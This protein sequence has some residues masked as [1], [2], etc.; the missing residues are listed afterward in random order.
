MTSTIKRTLDTALPVGAQS[1][2]PSEYDSVLAALT[3]RDYTLT[4]QIVDVVHMEF[5]TDIDTVRGQLEMAGM[6]VRPAP[7][8]VVEELPK[9]KKAKK[10]KS[11]KK[12]KTAKLV[13]KLVEAAQRHGISI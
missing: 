11:G 6:A 5:G 13:R 8:P 10:A 9:A 12:D 4:D 3:N 2:Y 1:A 7:E